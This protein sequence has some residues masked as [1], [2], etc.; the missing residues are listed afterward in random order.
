MT[1]WAFETRQ[2]HSGAVPD[3]TTGARAVPIHPATSYVFRDTAHAAEA[4]EL[5]DLTT[6]A[7]TGRRRPD[8]RTRNRSAGSRRM[9][10]T[11]RTQGARSAMRRSTAVRLAATA[12][13]AGLATTAYDFA[14]LVIPELRRRGLFRT[15]YTGRTLRDHLGLPRPSRQA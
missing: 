7:Y 6:H 15:H 14:E 3:P 2:V 11:S 10:H 4:F 8:R 9:N 13:L 12:V 1:N 5:A